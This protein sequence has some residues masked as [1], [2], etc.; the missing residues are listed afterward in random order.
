MPATAAPLF[1]TGQ[2]MD[3]DSLK[4]GQQEVRLF[5]I[6]APEF[7]QSCTRDGRR[8]ACGSAAAQQLAT[9]VN[10]KEVHCA[11]MGSDQYGRMLGRCSVGGRDLNRVM[12]AAGYALAYRRY[13][14]DYI[15]AEASAKAAKRGIWS[16][17]FQRPSNVRHQG[18]N[19][20]T[21][22]PLVRHDELDDR[23]LISS[24]RSRPQPTGNCRIK[25]NHSRRGEWIY[26]L[27]GMPYYEQTRAEAMFCSEAEARAAGYRRS[28]AH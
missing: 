5:G 14:M 21:N 28:R 19:Q 22:R 11:S 3:G 10:G 6:D 17:E 12:V 15:S 16:G 13:S 18:T 1:G 20:A 8:W 25:G 2:A 9:L 26:H 23:P 24:V 4:V 27:P 7:T